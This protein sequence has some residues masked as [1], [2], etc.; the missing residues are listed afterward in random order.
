M[1]IN[2]CDVSINSFENKEII[3]K[4]ILKILERGE[5]ILGNENLQFERGFAEYI[6]KKYCIGVANGTDAIEIAIESLQVPENSKILVQGNSCIATAIA[7][8]NQSK[9]YELELVDVN[10]DTNMIDLDDLEKKS[11]NASI[12]IVTHLFGFTPNME[13]IMTFCKEKNIYLIEDC[14]QAN[15]TTWNGQRAGNFGILSCFSFYPTKNLGAFGDGGAILTNETQLYEWIRKRSN[16]GS[17][18][19]NN[20]EIIG[21]NSRLDNIQAAV[22]NEKLPF[23]DTNNEKRRQVANIYNILLQDIA[24]IRTVHYD[25]EC[26]PVYH[27]YVVIVKDR[28]NL[29]T[30][31][32]ENGIPTMVHYP[33]CI[34]KTHAF[35][36]NQTFNTPNAD[37]LSNSILSLPMY[38]NLIN[39]PSKILYI[40]KK[41]K[42]FYGYNPH[43]SINSFVVKEVK[44]KKGL[45]HTI[46]KLEDF[47]TKRIF[48]VDGF[49]TVTLP[50]QRG[51][52]CNVNTIQCIMVLSGIV[53]IEVEDTTGNGEKFVLEANDLFYLP[54]KTWIQYTVLDKTTKIMVLCDTTFEEQQQITDY[55][56]FK[57]I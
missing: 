12:L 47:I 28:D 32:K 55:S 3:E 21:R 36:K 24:E 17:I 8:K 10:K 43:K 44:N 52:H 20:F 11:E 49:E 54:K 34:G 57:G 45:L 56:V 27:L 25:S 23:L 19:K 30:Y 50:I 35:S 53:L 41:I 15:G 40:V 46:N 7:V 4:K 51:Q 18:N 13:K 5:Y 33:I 26:N 22:L 37:E 16:M 2:F 6:G 1:N 42:D 48:Y 14:A 29:Q 38:P 31:L 9:S 39:E